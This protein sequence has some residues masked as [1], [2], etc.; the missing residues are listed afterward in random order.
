MH[1]LRTAAFKFLLAGAVLS[2][3]AQVTAHVPDASHA[4][5]TVHHHAAH[6]EQAGTALLM[7]LIM[8][9]FE[10]IAQ[11]QARIQRAEIQKQI[12]AATKRLEVASEQ[13]Q[14]A[15]D[16]HLVASQDQQL[17]VLE[18]Q[19]A[20]LE[21]Q[22]NALRSQVVTQH[23]T[24]F[25]AFKQATVPAAWLPILVSA[26][27]GN[28]VCTMSWTTLAGIAAVESGF[29]T[30]TLPGV[31][32][33]ANAKGAAGPM[34]FKPSTFAAYALPVPPGG[35]SPPSPYDVTDAVYAAARLL[36]TDGVAT[37]PAAAIHAYNHSSSYVA[38]VE[39]AAAGFANATAARALGSSGVPAMGN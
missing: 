33:G 7:H 6:H 15:Q 21:Q 1:R 37:H 14:L 32:S 27:T 23:A 8:R 38:Q 18:Q 25:V 36:C 13:Q 22:V 12:A 29:G 34:Q 9:P 2:V 24:P 11:I 3:P 26:A 10:V 28:G 19:L 17:A 39:A 16:Q 4:G 5:V 31:S 35:V 30:S 20:V